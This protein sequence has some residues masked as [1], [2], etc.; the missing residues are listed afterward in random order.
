[1][2]ISY[3]L[4]NGGEKRMLQKISGCENKVVGIK[5]TSR[6][7]KEGKAK[8]VYLAQDMDKQFLEEIQN[9]CLENNI[10]IVYVED[11]KK[12]G[13]ACGIDVKA[14]AATMLAENL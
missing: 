7:I 2:C 8:I 11:M 13:E 4:L 14:A 1:V 3:E 5:Q 10:E 6:A 12:L 9:L